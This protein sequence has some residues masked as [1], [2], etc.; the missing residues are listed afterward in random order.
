[1]KQ[2]FK[3]K[4]FLFVLGLRSKHLEY[5]AKLM[6]GVVWVEKVQK[7]LLSF[8]VMPLRIKCSAKKKAK[9]ND[10]LL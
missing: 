8:A 5:Y 1:M 6:L 9:Y 3:L 2:V 4:R 10:A 7:D